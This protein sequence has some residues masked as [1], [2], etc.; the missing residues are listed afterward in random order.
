MARKITV[1]TSVT[2]ANGHGCTIRWNY[3]GKGTRSAKISVAGSGILS[4]LLSIKF[5]EKKSTLWLC[6]KGIFI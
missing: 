3:L 4:N 1:Q 2:E 5:L 6:G